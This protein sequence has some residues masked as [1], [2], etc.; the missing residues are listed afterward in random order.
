[1]TT[2]GREMAAADNR[3]FLA[4]WAGKLGHSDARERVTALLNL[5]N[6][7][8]YLNHEVTAYPAEMELIV[9]GVEKLFEK[10]GAP[11]ELG[12][13]LLAKT[14]HETALEPLKKILKGNAELRFKQEALAALE[15][16]PSG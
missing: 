15:K 12:L 16:I 11:L 14:R 13:K 5:H 7:L 3:A 4:E 8:T 1:M 9:K 6:G 2:I 10:E